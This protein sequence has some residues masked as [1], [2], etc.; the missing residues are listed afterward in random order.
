M[1]RR[2]NQSQ[3]ILAGVVFIAV[4]TLVVLVLKGQATRTSQDGLEAQGLASATT[5]QR[6]G[7]PNA[8]QTESTLP[9]EGAP[10][11]AEQ[12]VAL[13]K[14]STFRNATM[15]ASPF[16]NVA[17]ADLAAEPA[18]YETDPAGKYNQDVGAY[19]TFPFYRRS[20]FYSVSGEGGS[21]FRAN[22][23][24]SHF[25]YDDPIVY[26]GE[27]ERAHLH[28]FLG[29]THTNAFSTYDSLLNSGSSTCNGKELNRTAYWV[30][31]MFDGKGGVVVPFNNAFYYKSET[32]QAVGNVQ[33]YPANLQLIADQR[34][35]NNGNQGTAAF[36]C[37][38]IYNGGKSE[39]GGTIPNCP[40]PA[41]SGQ[42]GT[43]EYQIFFGYCWNGNESE[44]GDW[45]ANLDNFT[46]PEGYWHSG[47][48]PASHPI[49]FPALVTHIFFDIPLGETTADW[50]LSSDVDSKSRQLANEPGASAHADWFG[51]WN[52]EVNKEWVQNCSNTPAAG[53][54][55]AYLESYR[56]GQEA[57]AKALVI[58]EDWDY[59]QIDS[60]PVEDIYNQM[61]S[62]AEHHPYN[63]AN[64]GMEAAY[65]HPDGAHDHG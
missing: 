3:A 61:C 42:P 23:E 44:V 36:R 55:D 8:P 49:T 33:P 9:S 11:N 6:S 1:W 34:F 15:D 32:A 18:L 37:N 4:A 26:P 47:K 21:T 64:G 53:C 16:I 59:G 54:G 22:C 29:N 65:C 5:L 12:A 25:S 52:P 19:G 27:P 50:Y 20:T 14:A 63:P 31:A 48:C 35:N 10:T 40:S 60:I 62:N 45:V 43:L 38:D 30:P 13:I 7:Q 28:M 56:N 17:A 51:A 58:R 2:L 41:A 46:S 57:T 39:F 24:V